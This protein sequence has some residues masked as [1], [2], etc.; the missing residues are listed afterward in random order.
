MLPALMLEL[1]A[2]APVVLGHTP[3]ACAHFCTEDPWV[4]PSLKSPGHV[5]HSGCSRLPE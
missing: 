3:K 1:G 2:D 5:W 4:G